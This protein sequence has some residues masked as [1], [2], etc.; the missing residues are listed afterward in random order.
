MLRLMF[1][2]LVFI[3][4]L[5]FMMCIC[6]KKECISNCF[7]V[8]VGFLCIEVCIFMVEDMCK[9]LY[10]VEW[11]LEDSDFDDEE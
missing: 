6:K 3:S 4:L 2:D 1:K 10:G 8:N 5:E 11:L 9:N 7:C